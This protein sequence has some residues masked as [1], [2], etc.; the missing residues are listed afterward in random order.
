MLIS[1]NGVYVIDT[2]LVLLAAELDFYAIYLKF[3]LKE[4][5]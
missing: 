1:H 2:G 4:L 3:R 5:I